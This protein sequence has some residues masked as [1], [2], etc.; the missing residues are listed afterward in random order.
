R[1]VIE[2]DALRCEHGRVAVGHPVHER[3]DAHLFSRGAPRGEHRLRLETLPWTLAVHRLEVIEAPHAV[4]AE[5]LR[6]LHAR[7]V[8]RPGH[9]LGGD[10]ESESHGFLSPSMMRSTRWL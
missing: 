5:A 1:D 4:E 10:V 7:Q 2:R 6:E 3:A 8:L 9:A